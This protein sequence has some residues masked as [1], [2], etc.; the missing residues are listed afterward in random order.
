MCTNF[1]C[2][3]RALCLKQLTEVTWP[4][5]TG[6]WQLD[7][8]CDLPVATL[9]CP[10][11]NAAHACLHSGAKRQHIET[12]CSCA[13]NWFRSISLQ[14][15]QWN[16]WHRMTRNS[17]FNQSSH[18]LP[19]QLRDLC[20][21]FEWTTFS[22]CYDHSSKRKRWHDPHKDGDCISVLLVWYN[23]VNFCSEAELMLIIYA[24]TTTVIF[25]AITRQ[26]IAH[27]Y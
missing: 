3:V 24:A 11:T 19:I 14:S 2:E 18:L 1:C 26:T 7:N 10:V 23:V 21:P 15:P 22:S 13:T 6:S 16:I 12:H 20:K 27:F 17:V 8:K 25:Q 9:K 5:E 4:T